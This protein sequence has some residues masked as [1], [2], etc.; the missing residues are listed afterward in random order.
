MFEGGLLP[1]A[2]QGAGGGPLSGVPGGG[3]PAAGAGKLRLCGGRRR[4]AP[5]GGGG[6]GSGLGRGLGESVTN[7]EPFSGKT[8]LENGSCLYVRFRQR[9][10]CRRSSVP[11][12]PWVRMAWEEGKERDRRVSASRVPAAP[13]SRTGPSAPLR[14]CWTPRRPPKLRS[15]RWYS[16]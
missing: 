14:Y 11:R 1:G 4:N 9:N 5:G 16:T 8:P 7:Q 13:S 12:L 6:P 10:S 15:S 2:S 3:G